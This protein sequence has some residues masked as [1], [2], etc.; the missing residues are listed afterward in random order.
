MKYIAHPPKTESGPHKRRFLSKFGFATR[1][2]GRVRIRTHTLEQF[3]TAKRMDSHKGATTGTRTKRV[4]NL[5]NRYA[6]RGSMEGNKNSLSDLR[7]DSTAE[8][9]A[10]YIRELQVMFGKNNFLLSIGFFSSPPLVPAT[11]SPP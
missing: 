6:G 2:S 11:V 8:K 4:E 3:A 1:S 5:L 7:G 10:A 9:A